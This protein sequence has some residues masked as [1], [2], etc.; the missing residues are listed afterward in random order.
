MSIFKTLF[1]DALKSGRGTRA[2]DYFNLAQT[3]ERARF[4]KSMPGEMA[5]KEA[6]RLFANGR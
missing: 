4:R 2:N 3:Q 5:A 1:I 6:A